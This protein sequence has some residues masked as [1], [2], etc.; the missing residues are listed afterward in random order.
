MELSQLRQALSFPTPFVSYSAENEP[1]IDMEVY[2]YVSPL[3]VGSFLGFEL[4]S[5][6]HLSVPTPVPLCFGD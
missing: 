1:I 2:F 6:G 4:H 5:A 3:G